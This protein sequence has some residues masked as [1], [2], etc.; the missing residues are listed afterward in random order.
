MVDSLEAVVWSHLPCV[1][2]VVDRVVDD[3]DGVK[4][5]RPAVG[6]ERLDR[7]VDGPLGLGEGT[8][9]TA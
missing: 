1:G 9:A 2:G 3:E 4:V 8:C 5:L 6:F 7:R